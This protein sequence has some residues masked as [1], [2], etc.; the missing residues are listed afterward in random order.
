MSAAEPEAEP[1]AASPREARRWPAWLPVAAIL[2][3]GVIVFFPALTAPLVLDDYFQTS[4]IEGTYPVA[5]SPF[6][7]YDFVG[8]AD[9]AIL[10]DRGLLPWWS[11]PQI[12]VR[13]FRPLSSV[14][15][16]ADHRLFGLRPFL[17]H[18]HSF[19]WWTVAALG[20]RALYR[21]TLGRR[22][23]LLAT[24]V[25][26]FASCHA[27]PMIWLANREVLVSVALGILAL[28]ALSR[29]VEEG[30]LRHAA[31]ATALF[32][33][34]LLGGEYALC[35]GG[36][37]LSLSLALRRSRVATRALGLLTFAGPA[38]AYLIVR[39]RL[40]YGADG[41]GLYHDPLRHPLAFLVRAPRRL[42][43]L[44][45]EGWLT[46]EPDMV[47]PFLPG[48]ALVLLV[49]GTA[50]L[51]YVPLR[52]ALAALDTSQREHAAWLLGGSLLATV[53]VLA[54]LPAPRVLGA[55][56]VG[57]AATVALILDRAWFPPVIEPRAG[58]GEL[59]GLCALALGFA[60]L[61]HSPGVSWATCRRTAF[62]A[63]TFAEHAAALRQRVSDPGSTEVV[64][65]RGWFSSIYVAYALDARG[66]PPA[67][68]RVLCFAGHA[69]V[70]RRDARTIE[71]VLPTAQGAFPIGEGNLF[72]G[73]GAP[74]AAG[75][76]VRV[77]GMRATILE[78]GPAGPHR[79][80]FEF[81][82][83]LESASR[84]WVNDRIDGMRDASPPQVGFGKTFD[85]WP[86]REE[87][88]EG[89]QAP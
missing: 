61:V 51:L 72:R 27:V 44:L 5:R 48:W 25:F 63:V 49:A 71:L 35:F 75:D 78:I 62:E 11:H 10:L 73:E 20:A 86:S 30:R 17:F 36:Y 56:M 16:Y 66:T 28:G 41:S 43:A 88:A 26:A 57:V 33:L 19:A 58:Q 50:L 24:I 83:P 8:D 15:L 23:G 81:D 89:Q 6:D 1:A 74:L 9:R 38:L 76:I 7:L 46:L 12:T 42:G 54:V 40:G 59:S 4:M 47:E 80:R 22:A 18:L 69:L 82:D 87:L 65:V 60:H 31:S 37:A 68:W 34:S 64:L 77:P 84:V 13:F 39:A 67:R 29:F 14:L 53:P 21:R 52:R 3:A 85:A 79:V 70:L 45:V 32:S 2:L 55:S